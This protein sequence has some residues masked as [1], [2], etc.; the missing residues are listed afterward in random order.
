MPGS[1]RARYHK[2]KGQ[3]C[4]SEIVIFSEN[5]EYTNN[6]LKGIQQ[7]EYWLPL[8]SRIICLF[9]QLIYTVNK[10]FGIQ[11]RVLNKKHQ[12]VVLAVQN[13]T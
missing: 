6:L 1:C 13:S 9:L 8:N 5:E 12:M 3:H 10:F 11:I 7:K 2:Q 4:C